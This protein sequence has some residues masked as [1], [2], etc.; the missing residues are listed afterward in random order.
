MAK[1]IVPSKAGKQSCRSV[2][3]GSSSLG[4]P[5]V[6]PELEI[7]ASKMKP[8]I[9]QVTDEHLSVIQAYYGRVTLKAIADHLGLNVSKVSRAAQKLGLG[10]CR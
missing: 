4:K 10:G 6:V 5:I 7:L 1:K 2:T 8:R 3:G 9:T